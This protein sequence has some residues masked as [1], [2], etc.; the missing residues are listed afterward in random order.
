MTK[1][2]YTTIQIDIDI[3]HYIREWC[4]QNDVIISKFT[5]RMWANHLSASRNGEIK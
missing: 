2:K 4:K 3:A 5:E 1:K